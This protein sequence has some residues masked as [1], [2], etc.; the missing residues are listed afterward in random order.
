MS[1]A[2]PSL[3]SCLHKQTATYD[4]IEALIQVVSDK[5]IFELFYIDI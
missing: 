4:F 2:R 5:K 1:D 3:R